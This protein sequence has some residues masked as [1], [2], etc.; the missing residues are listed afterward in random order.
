MSR[1]RKQDN[2]MII[3]AAIIVGVIIAAGVIWFESGSP[4]IGLG[5]GSPS[6]SVMASAPSGVPALS[7]AG[8]SAGTHLTGDPDSALTPGATNPDVTQANIKTTICKSGWTATIRPPS[9]Y[10]TKLKIS[11]ITAY[12]YTDTKTSSYEEDHLISLELGGNPTDA[13]NLW[14]EPYVLTYA[15]HDVGAH[16]K[17]RYENWLNAQVCSGKMALADAQHDIATDWVGYWLAVGAPSSSSS[18]NSDD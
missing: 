12:G 1:N 4:Q 15:G 18:A 7:S 13:H 3:L 14:P 9:S 17:D 6:A 16:A 8:A 10:T 11:Q 2:S 5:D